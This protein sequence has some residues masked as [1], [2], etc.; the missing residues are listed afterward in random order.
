[1]A[2]LPHLLPLSFGILLLL[3]RYSCSLSWVRAPLLGIPHFVRTTVKFAKSSLRSLFLS[4]CKRVPFVP[5]FRIAVFGLSGFLIFFPCVFFLRGGSF[6]FPTPTLR[7]LRRDHPQQF[8]FGWSTFP[9]PLR[10]TLPLFVAGG[11]RWY[12][13]WRMRF[14]MKS[15]AWSTFARVLDEVSTYTVCSFAA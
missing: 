13:F 7:R 4:F 3:V 1:M 6:F 12:A 11:A 5:W 10:D 2:P 9:P 14:T 8:F 15:K